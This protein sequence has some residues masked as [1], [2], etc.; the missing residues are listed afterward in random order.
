M[1]AGP[2][3]S[4]GARRL[5]RGKPLNLHDTVVWARSVNQARYRVYE[6]VQI[7][8]VAAPG[9]TIPKL[10]PD[11]DELTDKQL[12]NLFVMLTRWTD[13]LQNQAAVEEIHERYADSEVRRLEG[14]Y[15]AANKPDR[16]SE[17]V[18]W[19]RAQMESD[20][21]IQKAR[22]DLKL[23]YAR[24]KLKQMLFEAAERDAA[25]VSRELTRRTD[26]KNPGWQRADRGAP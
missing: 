6:E 3:S 11:I 8:E 10:E 4:S 19:V 20:P 25:V 26:T 22:D 17:A 21:E 2:E 12:M 1:P 24:R 23:F 16:V 7:P 18:T 14:L 13:F 15:M 5:R 9:F